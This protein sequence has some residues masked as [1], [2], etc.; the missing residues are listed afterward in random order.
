MQEEKKMGFFSKLFKDKG[1]R[2]VFVPIG[3]QNLGTAIVSGIAAAGKVGNCGD[4]HDCPHYAG[5][6]K[7]GIFQQVI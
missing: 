6:K 1:V 2:R 4:G 3:L 7:D 5:G